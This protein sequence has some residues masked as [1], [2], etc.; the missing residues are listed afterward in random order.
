MQHINF[1][2]LGCTKYFKCIKSLEFHN[3][4]CIYYIYKKNNINKII[5]NNLL[6]NI[7]KIVNLFNLHSLEYN[8]IIDKKKLL[9][10]INIFYL[11]NNKDQ[12]YIYI[13]NMIHN[14][15]NL[16]FTCIDLINIISNLYHIPNDDIINIINCSKESYNNIIKK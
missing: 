3:K 9:R 13:Y 2:C 10:D 4:I 6:N 1:Q 16:S 5:D 8:S 15:D 12:Y 7:T 11:L 14:I